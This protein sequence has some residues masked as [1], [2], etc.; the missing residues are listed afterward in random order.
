MAPENRGAPRATSAPREAGGT[1]DYVDLA[2][3][4]LNSKKPVIFENGVK[5]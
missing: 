5:F 3:N 1:E 2:N 4:L